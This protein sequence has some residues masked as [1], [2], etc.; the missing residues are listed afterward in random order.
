MPKAPELPKSVQCE[1]CCYEV[2][3]KMKIKKNTDTHYLFLYLKRK[4]P[5]FSKG[6]V[7]GLCI[8]GRM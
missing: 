1:T 7:V 2:K 5:E 8:T 3:I 4:Y 6:L